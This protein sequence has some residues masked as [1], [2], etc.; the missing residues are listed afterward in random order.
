MAN[1]IA[2]HRRS[3][4]HAILKEFP[5]AD[6]L[7]IV[8]RI[9]S[10]EKKRI[11]FSDLE[12]FCNSANIPPTSLPGIFSAYHVFINRMSVDRF[13]KFLRDEVICKEDVL[14]LSPTL[15][16]HQI[17]ALNQFVYIV[18]S[19]KTRGYLPQIRESAHTV[20]FERFQ[21]STTWSALLKLNTGSPTISFIRLATMCR[22]AAE[23]ELGI[24]TEDFI[25]AIF[26]FYGR[27]LDQINFSEYAQLMEA[28]A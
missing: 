26:A 9:K 25:D 12:R 13:T 19:R 1:L 10:P 21:L 15:L 6:L 24:S 2:N 3:L 16:D 14:P 8:Q 5:G 22:L 23:F 20:S 7:D 28:F 11:H 17:S 4:R 18:K 27:K